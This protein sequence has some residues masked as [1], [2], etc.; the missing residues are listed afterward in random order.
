MKVERSKSE[1]NNNNYCLRFINST[2]HFNHEIN[3]V[4]MITL[5]HLY[6]FYTI[7]YIIYNAIYVHYN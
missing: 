3:N 4:F 5:R 1:S 2:T 7:Y 6:I